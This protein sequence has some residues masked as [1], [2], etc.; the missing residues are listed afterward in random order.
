[1]IPCDTA[2]QPRPRMSAAVRSTVSGHVRLDLEQLGKTVV[3]GQQGFV[4][5]VRPPTSTTLRFRGTVLRARCPWCGPRRP[6][7]SRRLLKPRANRAAQ[8]AEKPFPCAVDAGDT[9]SMMQDKVTAVGPVQGPGLDQREIRDQRAHFRLA[10]H[11]AKQVGGGGVVF[12]DRGAP[13][14][15]LLSTN[16]FTS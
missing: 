6:G 3:V 11:A 7:T 16:T 12:D 2:M 4:Q 10:L 15:P 9:S 13:L 5:L 14:F 1:M 8:G